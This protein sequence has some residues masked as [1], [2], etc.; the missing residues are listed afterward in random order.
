M[1]QEETLNK[2]EARHVRA[3]SG[4]LVIRGNERMLKYDPRMFSIKKIG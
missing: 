1:R 4:V 2:P 3:Y